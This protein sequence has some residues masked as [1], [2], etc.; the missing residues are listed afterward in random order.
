[1]NMIREIDLGIN[2]LFKLVIPHGAKFILGGNSDRSIINFGI[3]NGLS[4][5][6]EQGIRQGVLSIDLGLDKISQF[7]SKLKIGESGKIFIIERSR[8]MVATSTS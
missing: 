7:L 2:L 1:M 5:H 3:Y 8:L 6:D 4:Y